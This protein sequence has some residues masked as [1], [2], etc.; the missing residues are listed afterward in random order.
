M[1]GGKYAE[2]RNE[3][4]NKKNPEQQNSD[5]LCRFNPHIQEIIRVSQRNHTLEGVA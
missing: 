5:S 4:T 2:G 3:E 1:E